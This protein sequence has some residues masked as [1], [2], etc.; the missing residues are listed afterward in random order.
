MKC[1]SYKFLF[2]SDKIYC[3]CLNVEKIEQHNESVVR[4]FCNNTCIF[5]YNGYYLCSDC[6]YFTTLKK[7]PENSLKNLK[8]T[9]YKW[10]EDFERM[11]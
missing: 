5:N 1:Y 10:L 6:F 7:I 9:I 11:I 8:K 2:T 3:Y 4:L